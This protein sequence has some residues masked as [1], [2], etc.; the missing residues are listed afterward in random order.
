[1]MCDPSQD[2]NWESDSTID[3]SKINNRLESFYNSSWSKK[4]SPLQLAEAGFIFTGVSDRVRCFSCQKTVE[5][6]SQEDDP[7]DRHIQVSPSC[8]F[9]RCTHYNRF[10]SNPHMPLSN[11]GLHDGTEGYI[12]YQLRTRAIVDEAP[13]PRNRNMKSEEA[14]LETFSSWPRSAPVRPRDLAQAGLFY[15]GKEDKVEC[16]SCGGKLSGWEPG[17]TPW[18][19]HEKHFSHCFYILGHDVGNVPLERDAGEN[20]ET[21]SRNQHRKPVNLENLDERLDTFARVQHPID[22]ELLA[23]AGFYSKGVGDGV[24]CFRC[25]GGLKDWDPEDNPWEEHAKYYPGC[26][27]LLSEKGQEFVNTIQLQEPKYSQQASEHQNGFCE[28][29]KVENPLEELEKLRQEKRCKICLDKSACIVF[30]PCGHLA[31]CK[32]CSDKLNQCPICC[33]AI[34]Q[35][36][37][38]FIA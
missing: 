34:A 7:V 19:E 1:M 14:R 6:W 29:E 12:D 21:G 13:Y 23:K 24:I 5:N 25:G 38:T 36:I 4:V 11:G 20:E 22:H 17:D 32:A 3:Y 33:A 2:G 30:I 18:N 8:T 10:K 15:L 9:L 31:S 26:S 35:K 27:F 37:R 16:F 28:E